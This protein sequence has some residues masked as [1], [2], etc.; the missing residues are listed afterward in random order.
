[1]TDNEKELILPRP[2]DIIGGVRVLDTIAI[3]GMAI[4][5]KVKHEELEVIRAIKFLK[6]GH[7]LESKQ[8]LQTEAKISAH[9]HHSNIVQIYNVAVWNNNP[10]IEMEYIDG[11]SMYDLLAR[12]GHFPITVVIAMGIILSKA[13]AFAHKQTITVYGKEYSG[14]VHRDIKPAN[15]LISSKGT[16]KLADFGIALPGSESIHTTDASVMGTGPY[17]S[18]EQIDAEK[19]DCRSD[20][21]SL[22]TVLYEMTTGEKTFPQKKMSELMRDKV[23]GRYIPASD[24]RRGIPKEMAE[25]LTMCLQVHRTKRYRSADALHDALAAVL[26]A[27]TSDSA[28]TLIAEYI[29]DDSI[30]GATHL[31]K[32]WAHKRQQVLRLMRIGIFSAIGLCLIVATVLV[33]MSQQQKKSKR[34]SQKISSMAAV[35]LQENH[36]SQ[37]IVKRQDSI[38]HAPVAVVPIEPKKVSTLARG[39]E[40]FERH[41]YTKAA[42]LLK[43]VFLLSPSAKTRLMLMWSLT[44]IGSLDQVADLIEHGPIADG[45]FVFCK[46]RSLLAKGKVL[47]SIE[48]FSLSQHQKSLVVGVSELQRLSLLYESRATEQQFL[49]KPN[50]HNRIALFEVWQKYLRDYCTGAHTQTNEC[51]EA[52]R[53]LSVASEQ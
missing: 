52:T 24:I 49:K 29:Q 32:T 30:A 9:L 1:M 51:A 23:H 13:L 11:E 7:T 18:P 19:L 35:S 12:R 22:G 10:Y 50:R 27:Y 17:I 37:E 34:G 3:G 5:Y 6:P 38:P 4:V 16:L 43:D 2:G 33:V 41:D 25:I 36:P 28:E 42:A 39:S 8:R 15:I 48:Q 53:A 14:L 40:A 20:I 47:E 21:Y 44:T 26:R 45:A 31:S 46:G